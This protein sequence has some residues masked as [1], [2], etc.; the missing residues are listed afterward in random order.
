[1]SKELIVDA[2][3]VEKKNVEKKKNV[4]DQRVLDKPP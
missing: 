4:S 1:M 3:T 2:S